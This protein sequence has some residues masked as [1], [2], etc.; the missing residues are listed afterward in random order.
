MDVSVSMRL[1]GIIP[2]HLRTVVSKVE[3]T[4]GHV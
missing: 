1:I 4:I 3:E 2:F